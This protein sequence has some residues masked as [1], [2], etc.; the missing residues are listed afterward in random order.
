M[1]CSLCGQPDHTRK[2]CSIN[3]IINDLKTQPILEEPVV[4]DSVDIAM[5]RSIS[6]EI[7]ESLGSGHTESVYHNAMKI[8]L[9]DNGIKFESERDII[10]KFRDRYVGT[11]RADIIIEN[12]LVIELKASI[13]TDSII[14]DAVEQCRIYMKESL[15]PNGVVVIFPKRNSGKLMIHTIIGQI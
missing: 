2:K 3:K 12:R 14:T 7:L 9:Q 10:I 5:I 15:I 6:T 8:A 11:V 1:P 4:V 13:G